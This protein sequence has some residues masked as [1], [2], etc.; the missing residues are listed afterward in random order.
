MQ[1]LIHVIVPQ[2]L[3]TAL[4]N[5][6]NLAIAVLK[7]TSI[8]YSIGAVELLGYAKTVV[9]ARYGL[10]QLWILGAAAVMY[11]ILCALL[12][13]AFNLV[14]RRMARHGTEGVWH[15]RA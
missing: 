14:S 12:E 8:A 13:L 3:R 11:A 10:G 5:L 4:P 1:N 6:K 2:T 9:A 7:D 15:E